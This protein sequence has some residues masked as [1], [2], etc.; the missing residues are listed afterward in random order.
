[1][2]IGVLNLQQRRLL[3]GVC[4]MFFN[5]SI[6]FLLLFGVIIVS[7]YFF[8]NRFE[9]TGLKRFQLIISYLGG[10]SA[11]LITYNIYLN[12]RS[13]NAIE[14]NRIAYNTLHNIHRN[15]LE[16]QEELIKQY[17]EGAFLYASMNQDTDMSQFLPQSFDMFKRKQIEIYG[18]LRVLQAA[19]DFLS[20]ATYDITGIYVW[21]N[22]FLLWMQSPILQKN[23]KLFAVIY[24]DD[25]KEFVNRIIEK[26][27]Y[28]V[29]LRKQKGQLTIQDYDAIAKN[30]K[31]NYR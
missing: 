21:I 24:S 17:P 31:V 4:Q 27:N 12:I 14:K 18:S 10:L 28:L 13:N 20:T 3:K 16:P 29:E 19:E 9:M 5:E 6:G 23:W 22:I 30:F 1:M 7:G 25:T 15:Y 26:A 2:V 11:L 8:V